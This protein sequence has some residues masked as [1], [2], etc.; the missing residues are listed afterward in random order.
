MERR[1]P[2]ERRRKKQERDGRERNQ[3]ER[4]LEKQG[5]KGRLGVTRDGKLPHLLFCYD[6]PG[7]DCDKNPGP[8][9]LLIQEQSAILLHH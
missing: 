1:G 3:K 9:Q 7:G 8:A 5:R 2:R 6:G 4:R